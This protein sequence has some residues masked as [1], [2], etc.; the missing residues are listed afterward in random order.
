MHANLERTNKQ[1]I[2]LHILH[3]LVFF[4]A[5]IRQKAVLDHFAVFFGPE[6][7]TFLD[8]IE[9]NWNDEPF[10]WGAPVSY[11]TPGGSANFAKAIR[12]PEGRYVKLLFFFI[13]I[14]TPQICTCPVTPLHGV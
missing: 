5:K 11:V 3:S 14:E 12:R 4:Q 6:V 9:K 1:D 7:F 2:H 8:Y 13:L 10:S